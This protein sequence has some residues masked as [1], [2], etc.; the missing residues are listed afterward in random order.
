MKSIFGEPPKM[1]L[2]AAVYTRIGGVV[3]L[4]T[5]LTPEVKK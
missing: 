2:A 3:S 4:R 1:V 5:A